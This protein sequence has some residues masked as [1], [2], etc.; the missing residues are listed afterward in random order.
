MQ[1]ETIVTEKEW[2][3]IGSVLF[4]KRSMYFTHAIMLVCLFFAYRYYSM[5]NVRMF[6]YYLILPV[7]LEAL[8]LFLRSRNLSNHM[9]YYANAYPE[10]RV[11]LIY[12]FNDK[13]FSIT[14]G[15]SGDRTDY[16]YEILAEFIDQEEYLIIAAYGRQFFIFDGKA[17]E[18]KGLKQFLLGK[19][20]SI[21][22]GRKKL[23]G[24]F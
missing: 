11:P 6:S 20:P 1:I 2:K 8:A 15:V 14:N 23:F 3:A 22:T 16:E 24:I 17:A 4:P 19:N 12:Q 5:G 18:E 13:N 9:K 7:G 10:K 21:R